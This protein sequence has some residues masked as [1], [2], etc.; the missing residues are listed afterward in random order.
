MLEA[1]SSRDPAANASGHHTGQQTKSEPQH[2]RDPLQ[3]GPTRLTTRLKAA[4]EFKLAPWANGH[5]PHV[6]ELMSA[7][8]GFDR[9]LH[10]SFV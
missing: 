8:L 5:T 2:P 1:G 10:R 6:T 7:V 9:P 4:F 3:H